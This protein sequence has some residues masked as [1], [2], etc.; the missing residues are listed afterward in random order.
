[1]AGD[2]RIKD[3]VSLRMGQDDVRLSR[4]IK[5]SGKNRIVVEQTRPAMDPSE[6]RSLIFFTYCTDKHKKE[7]MGFQA[8]IESMTPDNRIVIKQL[9]RSFVCDLRL[10]PRVHFN[11]LPHVRA[12]RQDQEIQVIDVSGGGTHLVLMD[13]GG[14]MPE[15]GFL[16]QI[17]FIFDQGETTAD[18]KIMRAWTDSEALRHVEVEF[19]GDPEISD[20]IYKASGAAAK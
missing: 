1:M 8:R 17:K 12:Y 5:F 14:E 16:V 13:D 10:W 20:F 6:I 19:I 2:L 7:R 11:L 15:T 9:S 4:F 3:E 18:G